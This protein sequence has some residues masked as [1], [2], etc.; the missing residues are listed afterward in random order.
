M[1]FIGIFGIGDQVKQIKEFQNVICPDCGT[2]TRAYLFFSYRYFHFFFIPVIKWNKRYY[3]R[4]RCCPDT[5]Y[6]ADK[7]TFERLKISETIDFSRLEKTR[8]GKN[9]NTVYRCPDCGNPVDPGFRFCPY[10]G[11]KM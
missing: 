1:F 8:P 6:T 7:E 10:C 9:R 3:V 4:L 2:Y 5:V 11:R